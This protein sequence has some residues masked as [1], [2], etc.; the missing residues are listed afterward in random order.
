MV[1]EK[2]PNISCQEFAK[3]LADSGLFDVADVLPDSGQF[4]APDGVGAAR[5]LVEAGKL[6]SY[7]AEAV[8]N[9]RFSELRMGN[10]EI[11]DRL[12]AGGMG[13]VFKARHRRMKRIV[14]LK[15]LSHQGAGSE[16]FAHRFQREVETIARLNHPNIVMAFDADEGEV[17]PFL[18]M[19]FVNGR[20]LTTEV[21]MNGPL[22]VA[23]A[24]D[25]I[26][27][28]ARGLEYAHSQGI[29][30][31]D[32]KPG[33]LL[34][35]TEGMV[36]V[37]D[38]G[39]ARL[40]D[41]GNRQSSLTQAGGVVGTVDYMSP[42]QA[43]DSGTVDHRADIYSLGCTLYFLL[44]ARPPYQAGSIL[45]IMLKHRDSPIPDLRVDRPDIPPGINSIFQRMVAKRPEDR[46]QS[47]AEVV[48][49]L[50][51]V[52][53]TATL[54]DT[55]FGIGP[56][57]APTSQNLQTI[58]LDAGQVAAVAA[59]DVG[60]KPLS[61]VSK[62]VAG[63][64]VV[65]AEPSRTQVGI[66]RNYL[67]QLGVT[68]T[69]ATGS[70]REAIELVKRV[71]ARVLISSAHLSDMT[72]AQLAAAL[73]AEPGGAAVGFILATSESQ[74]EITAELPRDAWTVV[75]VKPFDLERLGRSIA[76]VIA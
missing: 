41:P 72:G 47:M 10:Y 44:T 65:V 55:R 33:N 19:E 29:I 12:G 40:N 43:I 69:H 60:D 6:T 58:A 48:K 11:L 31:R 71:G 3:N 27:Q 16:K 34:R 22:S 15:V 50:E 64:P 7:Q 53:A 5:E 9:R 45:A 38:L 14:A 70:G 39:L 42:E 62:R 49:D 28:A 23:A 13:T 63:L 57:P 17:G 25:Q 74:S 76:K 56:A 61:E 30:H 26:L 75:M 2:P 24:V 52:R 32:I 20:D 46:H 37:A 68:N 8:L 18:V 4:R 35:D 73:R 36:K 21:T 51:H 66:I 54:T 1:E 59:G 67:Q